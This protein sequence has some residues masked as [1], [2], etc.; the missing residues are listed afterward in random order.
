MTLLSPDMDAKAGDPDA[1]TPAMVLRSSEF[2]RGREQAWQE[3]ER[4]VEKAERQGLGTL[5]ADELQQLPLLY[6]SALSSLSVARAIALDR[7]LRLYLENLG[8]RAFLVVYAPRQTLM[9]GIRDFLVRGFPARVRATRRHILLAFA[10][11]VV[12]AVAGFLLVANDPAWFSTLVPGG[13]G[14]DRS[15]ASTREELLNDE[16]FAPW[17]GFTDAF[18]VF[19]NFLFRHN[20]LV[21]LMTF[22]LGIAA[23]VPTLLLLA[24][25]GLV[26]GAFIALHYDRGL[27]LDFTG[28][29]SIHG[30]TEFGAIVLCGAGGLVI[31]Q[32]ILFPGNRSRLAN[33]A[34]RGQDAA[35]LVVGA[36]IL[37][38]IAGLIEGGMRQL[39]ADTTARLGI[40]GL[41]ALLWLAYFTLAGR[42]AA[43]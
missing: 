29:V 32:N 37:F 22:G 7:N 10:T 43:P 11:I 24:Y 28:W 20:T 25:Q 21:G 34:A 8:L 4:L 40:A 6:R 33:V 14:G 1:P 13:L 18:I 16:I 36:V 39:V 5:S 27:L 30:V 26:F 35:Q 9:E 2:R 31:A 41:T 23:G 12:G 3:L 42:K 19:A 15:E 38:F 17:P